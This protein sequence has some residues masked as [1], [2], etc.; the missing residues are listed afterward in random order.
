MRRPKRLSAAIG[1][2]LGILLVLLLSVMTAG[3]PAS[4]SAAGSPTP[5]LAYYYIWYTPT[6]WHRAKRDY[7]IV[8]RYSSDEERVMRQ[9]IRW[10]KEA[11][12]DGFI[13]S[14]KGTPQLTSRLEKLVEV[15]RSEHFKLSIVY[16]GLDFERQPQ[17]I[18]RV[19]QDF[20]LFIKRFADDEVFNIFG[21]PVLIWSGT[22]RFTRREIASVTREDRKDLLILASEKNARDYLRVRDLVDGDAYYWSSVNPDTFPGYPEKLQEMGRAVHGPGGL[23]IPPAAVGFDARLVGGTTVVPRKDGATL[24]VEMDAAT[25]SSPDAIGLI[26][27]NEFSENSQVE[28]SEKY[29]ARYLKALADINGTTFRAKV[30]PSSSEP[31]RGVAYGLPLLVGVVV[32]FLGGGILL[33]RRSRSRIT[34]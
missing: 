8:G 12:I 26:S 13:V 20:D 4:S 15:A 23:W 2:R 31:G 22:W 21:K 34:G 9:H 16:Q 27:W 11:G 28:P 29:G 17:P 14:W 1:L 19:A 32:F 3:V 24:R 7:P 18:K 30:D 33:R 10:A 6:S 5:V 25:E